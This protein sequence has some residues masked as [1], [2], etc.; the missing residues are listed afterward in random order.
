[1]VDWV[2]LRLR[3]AHAVLVLAA[4]VLA[5][6]APAPLAAQ[7]APL[8]D[9]DAFI[10]RGLSDWGIPGLG[11]A[12][13]HQDRVVYAR[14]FGVHRL[15]EARRVD[16]NTLFGIASVSKAFTAAALGMLVDEGRLS[17]DDPVV[18]HI[19]GF[20]LY[21][22]WV[23]RTTTI[24]D[25][26]AHRVGFG[27]MTGNRLRWLP[28]RERAELIHRIRHLGPE[29]SFRD[30]YVYSNVGYMIAGE[31][32]PAVTGT[33]WEQFVET[34]IFAPL[35]M[36][37]SNTSVTRIA[38][39]DNAAWPHQEIE[40]EVVPIA[41]RNF[42]AVGPAASIN[43]SVAEL[44]SWMRLHLGEPGVVDG[45]RLLSDTV[46][47]ELHRA[48]KV[49]RE[50]AF[51]TLASYA[52]GWSI[53]S[54]AGRRISSHSGATDGMNTI[55]MLV[56]EAD[57]GVVVTTNTFN[58]FMGALAYEVIDRMLDLPRRDWN[59]LQLDAYRARYQAVLREREAIH[60]ARQRNTAPSVPLAAFAG[61]FYDDL[62][63]D[64]EV[65]LVGDRL[66]LL[67]WQDESQI[68][69]LEHWHHDTFR[70]IWR[71]RA[72]REEFVWFSRGA[73]GGITSLH[74]DW[75]L[76]PDLLQVGA[77]PSSYRRIATWQR[78]SP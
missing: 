49:I 27:R 52:L 53:S 69:D 45:R 16:E 3:I 30:G 76:R 33:S 72:M 73:D 55:L 68:A 14:G 18:T 66:E 63:A 8:A 29:R 61:A 46:M 51:G 37:R 70:A 11:I 19:P 50:P 60:A 15:G 28:H 58:N 31:V 65:R 77:Y 2:P 22:P 4:A 42:D 48:Q 6:T 39:G 41:R 71:D 47:A 13:V 74:V 54:Y 26:L 64:A 40:R 78:V 35:G 32:I 67:L 21:D 62:Y 9:L 24:R 44:T 10:E 7:P 36:T 5:A 57:L 12:V 23:T 59:R 34:R 43:A 75:A 20:E 1:M 56:P 17:W 25:L 38:P